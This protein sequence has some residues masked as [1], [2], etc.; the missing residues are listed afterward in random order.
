MCG[1]AVVPAIGLVISAASTVYGMVESNKNANAQ[2]QA[3]EAAYAA[4]RK[5]LDLESEQ[6]NDK[7]TL[8]KMERQRQTTR[9]QSRL[10]AASSEVGGLGGSFLTQ[11]ANTRLQSGYDQGIIEKDRRNMQAQNRAGVQGVAANYHSR[12]NS[13]NSMKESPFMAGLKIAGSGMEAYSQYKNNK[14]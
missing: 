11:L 10:I 14:K 2:A 5:Q 9:E 6:I 1:P 7:T 13:A 8:E 4:D 3:A 12:L